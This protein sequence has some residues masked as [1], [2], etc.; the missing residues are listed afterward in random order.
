MS[1]RAIVIPVSTG[2]LDTFGIISARF[3]VALMLIHGRLTANV[4]NLRKLID[5]LE[6]VRV[7]AALRRATCR[8]A[9]C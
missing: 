7:L 9:P 2:Q 1:I 5:V 8:G 3:D 6:C 4:I